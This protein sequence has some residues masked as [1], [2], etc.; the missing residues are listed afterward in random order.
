MS[1]SDYTED[2]LVGQP[3]VDLFAELGWVTVSA[4]HWRPDPALPARRVVGSEGGGAVG[5]GPARVAGAYKL[6]Q[7]SNSLLDNSRDILCR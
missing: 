4:A 1:P 7:L 2:L 5:Q 6:K 3:A